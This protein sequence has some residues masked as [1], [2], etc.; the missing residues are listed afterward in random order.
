MVGAAGLASRLALRTNFAE[1]LP[2]GDPAVVAL[3]RLARSLNGTSVL[4]LAIEGPDRAANLAFADALTRRLRT[5]PPE[6]LASATYEI[7][8]ER[9]FFLDRRWLYVPLAELEKLRHAIDA[10]LHAPQNPLYVD[11]E[12]ESPT[13]LLDEAKARAQKL[14]R[15]PDGVFA[16]ADGKLVVIVCRPPGGPFAE[17]AG[18]QLAEAARKAVAE[19]HPERLQ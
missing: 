13:R 8:A 18:E 6:I 16:S 2:S 4:Q 10:R 9:Q 7:R 11:L 17:R 19:L 1:L 15:F 5:L 14:D 3:E 12:D